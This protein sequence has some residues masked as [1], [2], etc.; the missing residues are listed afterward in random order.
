MLLLISFIN[1]SDS[2]ADFLPGVKCEC[3]LRCGCGLRRER[4]PRRPSR[5]EARA[6]A[7]ASGGAS[8]GGCGL[9]FL[10][11]VSLW[12]YSVRWRCT[13]AASGHPPQ[14]GFDIAA[15]VTTRATRV[16]VP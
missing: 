9:L 8:L 10:R 7:L 4:E 11:G 15:L 16:V 13:G 14:G 2:V 3:D 1:L 5:S 6:R 12:L